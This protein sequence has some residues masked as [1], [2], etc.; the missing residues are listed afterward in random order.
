MWAAGPILCGLGALG[1]SISDLY[2]GWLWA[3]VYFATGFGVGIVGRRSDTYQR[4]GVWALQLEFYEA[5]DNRRLPDRIH[6]PWWHAHILAER[7]RLEKQRRF[8]WVMITLG[9]GSMLVLLAQTLRPGFRLLPTGMLVVY[10][11]LGS[12]FVF[13][14]RLMGPSLLADLDEL[15]RQGQSRGYRVG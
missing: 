9:G 11:M 4:F 13:W 6:P 14:H 15:A 10:A 7:H 1:I 5:Q 12:G 3:A 8:I 2:P